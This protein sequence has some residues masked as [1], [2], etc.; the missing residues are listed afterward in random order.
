MGMCYVDNKI[1]NIFYISLQV[2]EPK[3]NGCQYFKNIFRKYCKKAIRNF[4]KDKD[5]I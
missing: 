5:E 3:I 2:L 4:L 1:T